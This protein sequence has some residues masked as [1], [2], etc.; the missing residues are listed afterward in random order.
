MV[1][2]AFQPPPVQA[3]WREVIF[4]DVSESARVAFLANA[5]QVAQQGYW[6]AESDLVPN[7]VDVSSPIVADGTAIAAL[8]VP[9]IYK[10]GV[11]PIDEIIAEVKATAAAISREIQGIT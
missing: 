4:K 11:R 9:Y 8:T 2:Y 5:E 10:R 1:L 6:R 3:R 7:V